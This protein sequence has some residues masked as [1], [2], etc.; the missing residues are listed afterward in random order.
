MVTKELLIPREKLD[1]MQSCLDYLSSIKEVTIT[2]D[3]ENMAAGAIRSKLNGYIKDLGTEK[4]LLTKPYKEKSSYIDKEFKIVNDKLQNGFD[5]IGNAM[6]TYKLEQDRKVAL[7]QKRLE[8]EAEDKR[9][10]AQAQAVKQADLAQEARMKGNLKQAEKYDAA[11]E[12]KIEES[13]Q[14]VAPIITQEKPKGTSYRMY[15]EVSITDLEKAVNACLSRQD[16][17]KYVLIDTKELQKLQKA[18]DGSLDIEGVRF[19]KRL[20]TTSRRT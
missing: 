19:I 14:T 1:L 3:A 20:S 15:W 5:A 18:Y 10:K 2:N 4:K 12:A 16:L 8:A 6:G 7:E 11:V 17:R 13:Q 9:R